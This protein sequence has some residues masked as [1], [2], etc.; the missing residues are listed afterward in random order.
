MVAW[1]D[2]SA[3]EDRLAASAG[4]RGRDAIARLEEARRLYRGDLLDDCPIFGD[5]V[6]VEEPREYL[7]GRFEDLLLELGDRYAEVGEAPTAAKCFRQALALET[8]SAR[9]TERLARLGTDE[10]GSS[11]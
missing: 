1:S 7:R 4:V 5:S 3:F 10:D 8:G 6:F 9:A 11:D 2:V